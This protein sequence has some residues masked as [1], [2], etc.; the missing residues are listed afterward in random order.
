FA[1]FRIGRWRSCGRRPSGSAGSRT[2]SWSSTPPSDE[3][4][5]TDRGFPGPCSF[6]RAT[7][8]LPPDS[9]PRYRGCHRRT[10]PMSRPRTI[11]VQHCLLTT[12]TRQYGG[13]QIFDLLEVR[14]E[15]AVPADTEF[16]RI[17]PRF[18]LFLR[19]AS[20]SAGPTRLRIRVRRRRG[21]GTW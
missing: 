1:R 4:C 3:A 20:Q 8:R 18:D 10:S 15:Y 21:D 16:P 14:Y 19:F 13:R 2:F 12:M 7:D 11:A 6:P 9:D 5:A 17:V